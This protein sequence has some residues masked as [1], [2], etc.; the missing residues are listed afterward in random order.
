MNY[1]NLQIKEGKIPDQKY[2]DSTNAVIRNMNVQ[3][4]VKDS[5]GKIVTD[6]IKQITKQTLAGSGFTVPAGKIW[7]VKSLYVTDGG[8]YNIIVTS[9]KFEKPF[10]EGEKI[11]TPGWTAEGELLNGDQTGFFYIFKIEESDSKK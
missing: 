10:S 2:I 4:T 9:V 11:S 7:R 8:S 6:S 5:T 3:A 1:V